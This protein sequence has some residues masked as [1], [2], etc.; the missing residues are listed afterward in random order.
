MPNT[1]G[2]Y[3]HLEGPLKAAEIR[4]LESCKVQQQ[5]KQKIKTFHSRKTKGTIKKEQ[6]QFPRDMKQKKQVAF[7]ASVV[8]NKMS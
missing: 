5:K 7:Q 2:L 6:L 4:Q 8:V 1:S 3:R